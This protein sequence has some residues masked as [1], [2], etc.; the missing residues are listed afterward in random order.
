MFEDDGGQALVNQGLRLLAKGHVCNGAA[1]VGY[2]STAQRLAL[3]ER[4]YLTPG[5]EQW[6]TDR[7]AL[8]VACEAKL[9]AME[10]LAGG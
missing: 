10:V 1:D 3:I 7:G 8:Q 4:G 2:L 5:R 9:Y 6:L